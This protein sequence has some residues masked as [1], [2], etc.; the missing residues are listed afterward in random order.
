MSH[1]IHVPIAPLSPFEDRSRNRVQ[2]CGRFVKL[3]DKLIV[4]DTMLF[5]VLALVVDCYFVH[6]RKM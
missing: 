1:V 3:D 6:A 2:I 5:Q 4:I